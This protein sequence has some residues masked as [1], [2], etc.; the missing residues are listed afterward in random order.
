MTTAGF[1]LMEAVGG[2]C[3][4][5]QRVQA[6]ARVLGTYANQIGAALSTNPPARQCITALEATGVTVRGP[7]WLA[8]REL[9][10]RDR[11]VPLIDDGG[12]LKNRDY[13]YGSVPLALM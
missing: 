3:R 4:A 10:L 7:I 12:S 11:L 13:R 2:S 1:I 6:L 5:N 9:L 8:D